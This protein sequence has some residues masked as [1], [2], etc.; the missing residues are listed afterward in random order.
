MNKMY[1]SI[2]KLKEKERPLDLEKHPQKGTLCFLCSNL[3]LPRSQHTL[4][5]NLSYNLCYRGVLCTVE[6]KLF[7]KKNS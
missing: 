1:I 4:N 2:Y 3:Q 5:H 7:C 6:I